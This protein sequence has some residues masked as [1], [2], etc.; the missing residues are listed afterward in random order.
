MR[1]KKK[2]FPVEFRRELGKAIADRRKFKK[3]TQDD[4]AG[5]IEVDTETISRFERGVS[6]PSIE[7]LWVI[8]ETLDSGMAE[9]VSKASRL[10]SDQV[11]TLDEIMKSLPASEQQLLVDFAILLKKR[12]E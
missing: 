3:L 12:S 10:H 4:L 5:L 6:L 9:L 2:L 7:R 8:A 11:C 1:Q